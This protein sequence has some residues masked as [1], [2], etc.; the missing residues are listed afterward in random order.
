[1]M[2]PV[3]EAPGGKLRS[4]LTELGRGES[5]ILEPRQLDESGRLWSPGV[6]TGVK[7]DS[8]FHRTEY[9]GPVLAI[10]RARTLDEAIALQNGTDFGLTAGIHSLDPREV[11]HWLAR[12]QALAPGSGVARSPLAVG[13]APASAPVPKLAAP[14]ISLGWVR[15]GGPQPLLWWDPTGP[16][17]ISPSLHHSAVRTRGRPSSLAHSLATPLRGKKYTVCLRIPAG[18]G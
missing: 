5:W 2:G 17:P 11:E 15:G 12:V 6:R 10:M 16:T 9:F 14:T 13:N 3:I 8:K 1:M 18:L 7:A 4:G